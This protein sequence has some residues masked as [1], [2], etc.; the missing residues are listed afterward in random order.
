MILA[1]V[2][3]GAAALI[4]IGFIADRSQRDERIIGRV[5]AVW[6]IGIILTLGYT[7][8]T[9]EFLHYAPDSDSSLDSDL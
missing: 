5:L 8:A 3:L 7:I 2:I 9:G 4:T 1:G 6:A